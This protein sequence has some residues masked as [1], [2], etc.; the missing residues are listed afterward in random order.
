MLIWII[1][2]L[3]SAGIFPIDV[4]LGARAAG[5]QAEERAPGLGGHIKLAGDGP[6][7]LE[8]FADHFARFDTPHV[9][10]GHVIGFHLS[11]P[12]LE[13]P[14]LSVSPTIGACAA[15][16]AWTARDQPGV[17]DIRFAP[18]AGVM[19]EH[20]LN[21]KWSVEAL[22]TGYL[23]LGNAPSVEGWTAGASNKISLEPVFQVTGA[24][25]RWF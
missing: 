20:D 19:L 17:S 3:A 25:N 14:M 10:H 13:R 8:L 23:Y 1:T 4:A 11:R 12:L 18:H 24:V 5:W 22:G 15:L 21:S 16:E 9:W 6:L 7:E 2:A